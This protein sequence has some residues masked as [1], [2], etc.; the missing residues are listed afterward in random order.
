MYSAKEC[1]RNIHGRI[2]LYLYLGELIIVH[3]SKQNK[4]PYYQQ[5]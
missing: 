4:V 1:D 2:E 5:K 3:H